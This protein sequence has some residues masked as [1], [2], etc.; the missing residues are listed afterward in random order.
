MFSHI[1][2]F[3]FKCLSIFVGL[4]VVLSTIGCANKNTID[5][6]GIRSVIRNNIKNFQACYD[7]ALKENKNVYGKI[8]IV[9]QIV[10]AGK[11]EKVSVKSNS[12]GDEKFGKCVAD[13]VGKLTYPIPPK[14]QI[15]EV[16]YPFVFAS[17]PSEKKE[18]KDG[19]NVDA[20]KDE[21]KK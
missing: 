9:W 6:D 11:A 3:R 4:M 5:R 17:Q 7:S 2:N 20:N 12:T 13:E 8:E 1:I 16:I 18:S 15:A 14:T 21:N 10:D 19:K